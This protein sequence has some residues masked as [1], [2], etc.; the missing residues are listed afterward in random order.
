MVAAVV[1]FIT[2][3]SLIAAGLPLLTA[4]IGIAI[5]VGG[6]TAPTYFFDLS[7][8][9]LLRALASELGTPTSLGPGK[10]PGLRPV[11]VIVS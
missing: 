8:P 10:G 1:L 9:P 2:F 7:A 5:V 6:I 3:G 4:I 11:R